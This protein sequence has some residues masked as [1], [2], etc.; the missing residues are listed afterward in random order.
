NGTHVD[1]IGHFSR[2]GMLHGSRQASEHQVGG[3]GLTSLG[4][5]ELEPLVCRG[6]MLDITAAE[7]VDRLPREFGVTAGH[8]K[9]VA[10]SQGTPLETGDA[11]LVRTGYITLWDQPGEFMRSGA[12]MAQP[13]L[14]ADAG[15]YLAEQQVRLVGADT[16]VVEQ[17]AAVAEPVMA[18]HM[19]LLV[20]HGIPLL[21]MVNLEPLARDRVYEFVFVMAPLP[22]VGATAS[23]V[24]PLA[25]VDRT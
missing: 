25:V 21:E 7:G 3:R 5:E 16:P 11:V 19:I 18:V 20:D 9:D 2:D 10:R 22:L 23:P 1:A 17:V 14:T 24:R 6:V 12:T 15:A 13:G 4:V 8:I